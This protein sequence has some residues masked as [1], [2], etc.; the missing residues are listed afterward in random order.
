[1][2]FISSIFNLLRFNQKNWKAV[3][4]CIFT[5]TVF[6]FFN[7]L[8]KNYTANITFPVKI[9]FDNENYIPVK[10][11]PDQVRLN[12]SGVGWNLLR[13]SIGLKLPPLT[14]PL[15]RPAD[16]QK[17]VGSTLPA[18]FSN[19]VEGI[20]INFV[21]TDTL[22]LDIEPKAHRWLSL[23]LDSAHKFIRP[24]WGLV[25]K[26]ILSPDSVYLEGPSRMLMN[27]HE[28]HELVLPIQNINT[29]FEELVGVRFQ[30]NEFIKSFPPAVQVSFEVDR[31]VTVSDSVPLKL[32]NIPSR[33]RSLMGT[34]KVHYSM[35]IPERLVSGLQGD[36]LNA[37]VDLK[38]FKAGKA[39]MVPVLNNLP[40]Y[41]RNIVVDTI[42]VQY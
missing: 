9:E 42:R 19:Q 41:A 11:L 14:I 8:N 25:S 5:A 32:V 1:M 12:V 27:L 10:D 30:Y 38:N 15:E 33:V 37:V 39:K 29:N 36:S 40:S 4:L 17:I 22:Y 3:G 6:W 13:R 23:K 16:V 31:F 28:P 7:A 24:G 2:S 26:P 21:I 35:E 20:D 18:L 34:Q